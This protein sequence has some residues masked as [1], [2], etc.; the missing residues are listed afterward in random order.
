MWL[1]IYWRLASKAGVD[2][3]A[4]E[5]VSEATWLAVALLSVISATYLLGPEVAMLATYGPLIAL[6]WFIDHK[7]DR[8]ELRRTFNRMLPFSLLTQGGPISTRCSRNGI[9]DTVW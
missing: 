1:P 3:N 5:M 9:I 2:G 8:A 7:P 4:R 6:R